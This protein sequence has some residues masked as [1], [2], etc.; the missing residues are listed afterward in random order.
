MAEREHAT[1]VY[2]NGLKYFARCEC[3]WISLPHH[4]EASAWGA[5]ILHEQDVDRG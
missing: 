5:T 1:I 3:G 2:R 4:S